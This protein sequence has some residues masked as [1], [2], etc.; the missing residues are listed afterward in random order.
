MTAVERSSA[1]PEVSVVMA[2]WNAAPFLAAS[3][4]SALAQADVAVEIIIADDASEDD[5]PI[6]AHALADN[7]ARVVVLAAVRNGGPSAARNRA[8]AAARGEWIAVLDAD[9]R[10]APG[11]LA[12]LLAFARTH[13]ADLVFDLF[14]EVDEAGAPLPG[15]RAP[16]YPVAERWTLARWVEDNTFE[17]R[18]ETMG[19]GYLKPLIRR[20]F[21]EEHDLRYRESLR[22]SEDYLLV[23]EILAA[24][25]AV[26][27]TPDVGYFYTRREG[28]IS[29][30]IG[31]AH[32]R[33][34]LAEEEAFVA[35]TVSMDVETRTAFERRITALKNA[36]ACE[37]AIAALKARAPFKAAACLIARPRAFRA[38][39]A[40]VFEVV[41]KRMRRLL[42]QGSTGRP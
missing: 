19:S 25:G 31:P 20:S 9:D 21:L 1:P 5:T 26:W 24:N 29:H 35:R 7:D 17:R 6:M 14:E 2:A 32:L 22:N 4:S 34:L 10:F 11:R 30:R 13:Q 27:T 37:E 33:A 38:M 16:R 3:V 12:R 36:L 28:S 23:A 8:I 18:G 42:P 40:W 41:S 39:G 15:S